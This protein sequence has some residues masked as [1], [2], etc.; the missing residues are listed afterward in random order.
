[1]LC[2]DWRAL[3]RNESRYKKFFWTQNIPKSWE[4]INFIALFQCKKKMG[5]KK[6]GV[7]ED[8]I[9]LEWIYLM[10]MLLFFCSRFL[11]L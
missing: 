7:Y 1:M 8:N 4:K 10:Q 9:G 5:L 6:A 3:N 11:A 2:L